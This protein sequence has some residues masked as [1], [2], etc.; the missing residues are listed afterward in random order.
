MYSL[1]NQAFLVLALPLQIY[2]CRGCIFRGGI[3]D[4]GRSVMTCLFFPNEVFQ[5]AKI[6]SQSGPVEFDQLMVGKASSIWYAINV[7]I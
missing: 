1:L 2:H 3:F 4:D 7:I 6:R 5:R